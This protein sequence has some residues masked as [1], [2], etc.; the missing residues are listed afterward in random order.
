MATLPLPAPGFLLLQPGPCHDVNGVELYSAR[1]SIP[2]LYN[3]N[4]LMTSKQFD[5][6]FQPIIKPKN[7]HSIIRAM[8]TSH[9]PHPLNPRHFSIHVT[10]NPGS[11]HQTSPSVALL[12]TVLLF[13]QQSPSSSDV[14]LL[15]WWWHYGQ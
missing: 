5:V 8:Y 4:K 10:H 12:E 15:W 13:V 9:L 1:N 7:P 6:T 14:P 2:F 3:H 11:V